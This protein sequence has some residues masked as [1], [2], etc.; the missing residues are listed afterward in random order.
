[1]VL[2]RTMSVTYAY[3]SYTV[4]LSSQERSLTRVEAEVQSVQ[5]TLPSLQGELRA[6]L[7]SQLEPSDQQKVGGTWTG[8]WSEPLSLKLEG[9]ACV[10]SNNSHLVYYVQ[11]ER[12]NYEIHSLQETSGQYWTELVK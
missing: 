2:G 11:V 6:E 9:G 4:P 8:V 5:S 7:H 10:L 1:M 3:P 12:L